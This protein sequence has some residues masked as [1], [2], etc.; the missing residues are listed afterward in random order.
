MTILQHTNVF[1]FSLTYR[2]LPHIRRRF[3]SRNRNPAAQGGFRTVWRNI[4]STR[5]RFAIT[6][7]FARIYMHSHP[8]CVC[9][10]DKLTPTSH[11]EWNGGGGG[12]EMR[13]L[14]HLSNECATAHFRIKIVHS[15]WAIYIA[16]INVSRSRLYKCHS[17]YNEFMPSKWSGRTGCEAS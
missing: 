14:I 11:C 8:V 13:F 10:R 6:V 5:N 1:L 3:E 4:V 2:T 17:T 7:I 15:L 12:G 9:V 16:Y